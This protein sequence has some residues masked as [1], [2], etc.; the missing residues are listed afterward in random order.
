MAVSGLESLSQA[1]APGASG[2]DREHD[3]QRGH[4]S[5]SLSLSEAPR[6]RGSGRE[7]QE[8]GQLP[9]RVPKYRFPHRNL[10]TRWRTQ[11]TSGLVRGL[12]KISKV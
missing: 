3:N 7:S 4:H 1:P 12:D 11:K 9:T 6:G 2:P 8:Q 10:G 5:R